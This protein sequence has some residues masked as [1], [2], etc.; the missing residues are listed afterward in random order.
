MRGARA[1]RD[2]S[3]RRTSETVFHRCSIVVPSLRSTRDEL[4][5][6]RVTRTPHNDASFCI[7]LAR[8]RP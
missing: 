8:V 3:T 2:C 5:S 7:L 4:R 1:E 6:N